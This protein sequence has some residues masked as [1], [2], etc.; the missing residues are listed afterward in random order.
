MKHFLLLLLLAVGQAPSVGG[1]CPLVPILEPA[2]PALSMRPPTKV[3]TWD[4]VVFEHLLDDC[5]DTTLV[6]L[7]Q[8]TWQDM[9]AR[10]SAYFAFQRLRNDVLIEQNGK[11]TLY[12]RTRIGKM[13][14]RAE[15]LVRP[16]S[17]LFETT[18][19]PGDIYEDKIIKR[20][21]R[22]LVLSHR[23]GSLNIY[24]NRV[25]PPDSLTVPDCYFLMLQT[26]QRFRQ[27]IP[28]CK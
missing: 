12:E 1:D 27:P 23:P 19:L 18:G 6:S 10:T 21:D 8:H 4:L 15:G 22:Y 9:Y 20:T 14:K 24:F 11:A 3:I 16:D 7:R 26:G 25:N 5:L 13:T 28:V 17:F 2:R